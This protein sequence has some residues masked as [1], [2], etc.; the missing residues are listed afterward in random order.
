MA[1]EA[2][3]FGPER[4][5]LFGW[6]TRPDAPMARGGV[7]LAQPIGREARA[8]RRAMRALAIALARR[9]YL[10]VRVDY[11][12]VGDSSGCLADMDIE[13]AWVDAV[14][15]GVALLRSYG[16]TDVSAVGMRLGATVLAM[17]NSGG[18][19]FSSMVLWDP[20][21]SG[22]SF[23]REVSALEML[24]RAE[25]EPPRDGSV[26]T[27]EWVFGADVA[28]QIR[29]LDLVKA[30]KGMRAERILVLTRDDR[31]MPVRL[32]ECFQGRAVL[33][34][35]TSE[36]A[37][38]LDVEPFDAVL[39][40]ETMERIVSWLSDRNT[41]LEPTKVVAGSTSAVVHG[42]RDEP[43]VR[44]R[45][46]RVGRRGLFGI[47]SETDA[48]SG[49]PL[50]VF[51]NVANEEH[52]GPSRLWVDLSRRWSGLGLRCLRFDLSG[53]GDSPDY[54]GQPEYL[55]YEAKWLEDIED[56][57]RDM[58]P[59]DCSDVVFVGLCSGAYL[60]AEGALTFG[61]RGACVIN[62]PV[63]ID[64]LHG[65]AAL[66]RSRRKWLRSLAVQMKDLELRHRWVGAGLWQVMRR[67][68]PRRYSEDLMA[69]VVDGGTS[70]LVL[71]S[72]EDLS[73]YPRI[74]VLRSIDRRRVISPK[75]YRAEFVP[76]LDHSMHAAGGR[77]MAIEI[78]DRFVREHFVPES[79]GSGGR[80]SHDLR[81]GQHE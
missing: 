51:L 56:V 34:G 28:E 79:L 80:P 21:E 8:A 62:P 61:A 66:D 73:P 19:E 78:L 32:Q 37:A 63:G 40:T 57:V 65:A 53:I 29:R 7:I 14:G 45:F 35:A 48:G 24:R 41:A 36:Q 67:F 71:A 13:R 27:S 16:V 20:C 52:T 15:E 23:L 12:G 69:T 50:V 49:G 77:D 75:N 9:G 58:C 72:F 46:V 18:L 25:Y 3:W 64:L 39:A 60:A 1:E 44:E 33:W 22:R 10:V 6:L 11:P 76:G 31:A 30:A 54:L 43:P 59:Q 2:R 26:I 55:W 42:C 74:P 5:V 4:G 70:L 47:V 38:M 17:A 68:L 81:E